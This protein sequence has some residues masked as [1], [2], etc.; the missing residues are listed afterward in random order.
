MLALGTV[1]TQMHL[2]GLFT[3]GMFLGGT[4]SPL[5]DLPSLRILC[6]TKLSKLF[7][8]NGWGTVEA[9]KGTPRRTR[10]C[11]EMLK[12]TKYLEFFGACGA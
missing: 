7:V 12:M 2:G 4:D 3:G 6:S 10:G 9:V 5:A 11:W 8:L 1:F